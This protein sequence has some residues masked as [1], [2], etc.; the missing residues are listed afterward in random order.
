[1]ELSTVISR[2]EIRHYQCLRYTNQRLG[3]FQALVGPNASGKSAFLDVLS[4]VADLVKSGPVEAARVRSEDLRD[5]LWMRTGDRFEIAVEAEV[6]AALREKFEAPAFQTCRYEF[7]IGFTPA[8]GPAGVLAETLWLHDEVAATSSARRSFPAPVKPP[9]T[10]IQTGQ[11]RGWNWRAVVRKDAESGVDHFYSET[12]G[13]DY[14]FRLGAAQSALMNLPEDEISFPVAT[15]FRRTLRTGVIRLT[16]DSG[17]LRRPSPQRARPEIQADGS[18]LPWLIRDLKERQSDRFAEWLRHVQTALPE[19]QDVDVAD[20]PEEGS[21]YL[22]LTYENGLEI[23]SWATSEG[24]LRL[25]ALTLLAYYPEAAGT[26]LIEEPEN[27]IHPRAIETVIQSLSSVYGAQ[28][29]V[30]THSPVVLGLLEPEQI[31]CFARDKEG[32]TDIIAGSDHPNLSEWKRETDL[33]TVFAT[34]ILG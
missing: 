29:L 7:A 34:G 28:V 30:A 5:L 26:Y 3:P 12:G 9:P 23:K 11:R 16:L 4:F 1:M 13:E 18:S 33:G 32:A 25:L 10:I 21:C 27:G 19:L 20:R 24:T 31:L 15:W 17:S 8:G 22:V 14:S 6:P 2:I